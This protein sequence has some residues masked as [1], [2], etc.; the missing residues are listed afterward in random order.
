MGV[1]RCASIFLS[2]VCCYY[3]LI[4]SQC[5]LR[6]RKPDGLHL[7]AARRGGGGTMS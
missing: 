4:T 5:V 2:E 3:T 1:E 6:E 7:P